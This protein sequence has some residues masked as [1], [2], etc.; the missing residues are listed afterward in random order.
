VSVLYGAGLRRAEA[1]ALDVADYDVE[2]GALTVRSGKGNKQR[3]AYATNG[4]ARAI[5]DWLTVRGAEPG[6]LF[7]PARYGRILIRRLTP[8]ALRAILVRRGREA[9]VAHFS[10]HDL[11]RTFISDLLDAGADVSAVQKLAG[12]ANVQ[13]TLRYD[14][15]PE[16]AKRRAANLIHVPYLGRRQRGR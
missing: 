1:A 4:G 14:R 8:H 2:T 11:R 3:I 9:T 13:T 6:P 5:A 16:A 10:P 15:R 12:H 7:V